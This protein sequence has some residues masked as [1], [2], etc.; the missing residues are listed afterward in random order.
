M[1]DVKS[2]NSGWSSFALLTLP[3]LTQSVVGDYSKPPFHEAARNK[4][5]RGKPLG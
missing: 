1:L 3:T 2:S 5:P 4:T